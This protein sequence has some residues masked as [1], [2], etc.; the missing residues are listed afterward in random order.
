MAEWKDATSY[1]QG[2][3]GKIDPNSWET[4]IANIQ[5]WVSRGHIYNPE[6]WVVTSRELGVDAKPIANTADLTKDQALAE[7]LETVAGIAYQR[8]KKLDHFARAALGH[9]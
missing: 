6:T 3:R 8:A 2:Q 1:S 4:T 5:V 9:E 7:A